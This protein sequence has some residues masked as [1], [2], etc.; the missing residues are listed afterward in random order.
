MEISAYDLRVNSHFSRVK[1]VFEKKNGIFLFFGKKKR[2]NPIKFG[3]TR[4][5]SF[6]LQLP[7][8]NFI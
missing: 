6:I 8:Y 5:K 2:V 7:I 3:I 4:K 1:A